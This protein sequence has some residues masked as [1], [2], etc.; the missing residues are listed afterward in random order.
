M[1]LPLFSDSDLTVKCKP[2]RPVIFKLLPI[3]KTAS[4]FP[5]SE[6]ISQSCKDEVPLM[7][8]V[9]SFERYLTCARDIMGLFTNNT[10]KKLKIEIAPMRGKVFMPVKF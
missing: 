3:T 1:L 5:L 7:D 10:I 2:E 6:V 8:I 4:T 9:R